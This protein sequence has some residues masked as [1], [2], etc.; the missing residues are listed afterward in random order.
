MRSG[1]VE[2]TVVIEI[3]EVFVIVSFASEVQIIQPPLGQM[4]IEIWVN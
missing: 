1:S 4:V 2:I 3:C